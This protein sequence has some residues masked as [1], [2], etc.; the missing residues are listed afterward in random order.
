MI[1]N[2]SALAYG[3]VGFA[4]VIGVGVVVLQKFGD[5]TG[6]TANTTATYLIGQLG[7]SGLAS[8]TPAIVAVVI[9]ALFL[10]MFMGKRKSY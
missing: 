10:A 8:W 1:G 9:G 2:V 4:L 6:G 3:I 5:A 7:T